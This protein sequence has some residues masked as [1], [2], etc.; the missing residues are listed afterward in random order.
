MLNI[1]NYQRN[2]KKNYNVFLNYGNFFLGKTPKAQSIFQPREKTKTKKNK[3]KEEKEEERERENKNDCSLK[4]TV[5][6]MKI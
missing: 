2:A 4:D 3:K 1:I 5:K 6:R